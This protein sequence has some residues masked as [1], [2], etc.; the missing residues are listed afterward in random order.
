MTRNSRLVPIP[1]NL[2]EPTSDEMLCVPEVVDMLARTKDCIVQKYYGQEEG[3]FSIKCAYKIVIGH[4]DLADEHGH[5]RGEA[6]DVDFYIT[7]R[8]FYPAVDY[9]WLDTCLRL[10]FHETG[11]YFPWYLQS[12]NNHVSVGPSW[13][14]HAVYM[15]RPYPR[16]ERIEPPSN[17]LSILKKARKK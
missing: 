15:G 2:V 5:W 9:P 4:E 7:H 8:N 3:R 17:W 6:L 16:T 14:S 10:F 11:W 1:Y 12:D 13:N